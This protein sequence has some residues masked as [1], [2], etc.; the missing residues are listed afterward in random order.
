[1][2]QAKQ[3][4]AELRTTELKEKHEAE[5]ELMRKEAEIAELRHRALKAKWKRVAAEEERQAEEAGYDD[6]D[7]D[8]E[9]DQEDDPVPQFIKMVGKLIGGKH[10]SNATDTGSEGQAI[11]DRNAANTRRGTAGP[12]IEAEIVRRKGEE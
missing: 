6:E 3:K 1:M 10:E 12:D 11:L 2:L 8:I 9:D 7:D 4:A 5:V